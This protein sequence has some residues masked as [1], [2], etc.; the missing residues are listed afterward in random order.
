MLLVDQRSPRTTPARPKP[1]LTPATVP[2]IGERWM[3]TPPL[4]SLTSEHG[5][6]AYSQASVTTSALMSGLK[7]A[8]GLSD[9]A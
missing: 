1:P 8:V 7:S 9:G 3:R 4:A 2:S 6:S 5:A